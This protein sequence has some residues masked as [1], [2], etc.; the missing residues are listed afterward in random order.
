MNGRSI[1]DKT[2]S[3]AARH[4]Y[5][6]VLFHGRFPAYVLQLTMDPAMVDANAHPAKHEIRF[7][8]GRNVHG[9]VSQAIAHALSDTRPQPGSARSPRSRAP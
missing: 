5:R 9:F 2:L 6:D 1:G 8:D 4:A 3:H 7:R